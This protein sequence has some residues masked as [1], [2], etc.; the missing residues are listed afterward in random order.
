MLAVGGEANTVNVFDLATRQ[1]KVNLTG[2][3]HAVQ[4]LDFS[5][6]GKLLASAGGAT[7]A[8]WDTKTWM[9]R[10]QIPHHPEVVCVRFS[11]DSKLLAF[12]DGESDLPHY[13]L[14]PTAI[15]LW[16]I[17]NRNEVRWMKGHINTIWALAFSPDGKTL[18]SGSADQTVKFWDTTSGELRETIVPGESGY[19]HVNTSLTRGEI[20]ASDRTIISPRTPAARVLSG[21]T[22]YWRRRGTTGAPALKLSRSL[23]L[24]E[25]RPGD[26][27][28]D[29]EKA[30]PGVFIHVREPL[31]DRA[32]VEPS[33]TQGR[34]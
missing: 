27:L 5:P 23:D 24:C 20:R 13:K 15:I 16:D 1:L 6:D 11:P 26:G 25:H 22:K 30:L 33:R 28:F 2:H 14:L 29:I 31:G 8:L 17:A 32:C 3:N 19:P 12:S 21:S 9:Q 34:G 10:E 7:V 4:S 18:A